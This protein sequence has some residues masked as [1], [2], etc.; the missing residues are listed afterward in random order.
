MTILQ[1]ILIIAASIF[2][3]IPLYL[4]LGKA[5]IEAGA[6]IVG[7]FDAI[8]YWDSKKF[9]KTCNETLNCRDNL[10][11]MKIIYPAVI[12]IFAFLSILAFVIRLGWLTWIA[13]KAGAKFYWRI[14]KYCW[15]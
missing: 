14:L 12:I 15:E 6:A 2:V 8:V 11:M 9:Q 1:I 10:I 13:I 5:G 3:A 7:V 4:Y